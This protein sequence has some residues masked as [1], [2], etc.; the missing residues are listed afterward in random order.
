MNLLGRWLA[1]AKPK[2]RA[3]AR[4][5]S[6]LTSDLW[7]YDPERLEDLFAALRIASEGMTAG[8][9]RAA[10]NDP[11]PP[12]SLEMTLKDGVARI[13]LSGTLMKEVPCLFSFFDLE[14]TS[15]A[16]AKE[17]IQEAVTDSRVEAIMLE[18]D[19]PGGTVDGIAALADAI[20]E[21]RQSK[22]IHA[23]AQD[24]AASAAIWIA[25]QSARFTA[26]S[27][28]AIGSIG[29]FTVIDDVSAAFEEAGVTTHV[30]RFGEFKGAGI[31]GTEVTKD[32]LA[33]VQRRIDAVGSRFVD[34]VA[35]GRK[36]SR[37]AALKL[38]TGQVWTGEEAIATGLIDA[39]ESEEQAMAGLHESKPRAK[40]PANTP[41]APPSAAGENEDETIMNKETILAKLQRGEKLTAAEQTFIAA[42]LSEP[43]APPIET[44]AD[45][46]PDV[47]AELAR[48][49]AEREK[50]E[51]KVADLEAKERRGRY[52]E[53]AETFEYVPALSSEEAAELLEAA[54]RLFKPELAAKVRQ[55]LHA[56]DQAMRQSEAFSA[57]GSTLRGGMGPEA[58]LR[59]L[60][61]KLQADDPKLSSSEAM[62]QAV[63]LRPDLYA[64][65]REENLINI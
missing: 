24:L 12:R 57:L 8:D 50:L 49:K 6:S 29:V 47:R 38:A 21:A 37:E 5:L 14:A 55:N 34:A 2:N 61:K 31:E 36:M 59:T 18:I 44:R 19:S 58:E 51:K 52:L 28:A 26:G 53:E 39:I 25:S 54:D 43:P 62:T 10:L 42:N 23:Y 27:T 64:K 41:A 56:T 40:A 48:E 60:A 45:L 33:E 1:Q 17:A 35:R 3:A 63:K 65:L 4:A 13:Q 15:V 22:P 20:F 16:Q 9:I 46:P 30:V 32:Q 7:I 11:R